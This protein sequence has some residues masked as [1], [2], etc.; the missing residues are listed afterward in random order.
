MQ[1]RVESEFENAKRRFRDAVENGDI[2]KQ[3]DAQ[4]DIARLTVEA[5]KVRSF[6]PVEIQETQVEPEAR[7]EQQIARAAS[8]HAQL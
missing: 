2:D 1:T 7:Y 6:R 5:D 3:V 4:K 8:R